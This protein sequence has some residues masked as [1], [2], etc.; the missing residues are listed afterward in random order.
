MR[1]SITRVLF[2]VSLVVLALGV[3]SLAQA[4]TVVRCN[5]PFE[6]SL[7]G[8][9][10]SSGIY[11]F[12]VTSNGSSRVVLVRNY[13]GDKGQI[14]MADVEDESR[15]DD[16]SVKFNHLGS[17]YLFTSLSIGGEGVSLHV[18][19]TRAE[20]EMMASNARGDVVTVM[21]SR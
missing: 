2:T 14:L 1:T 3:G 12:A 16:T 17:H 6:F 21:A 19:P 13:V 7:G 8:Q 20:R 15:S 10:Y 11:T 4:Q 5:I 9:V 18:S